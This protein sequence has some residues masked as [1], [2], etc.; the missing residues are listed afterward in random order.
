MI[1]NQIKL[2]KIN[3]KIIENKKA[4]KEFEK[5][6]DLAIERIMKQDYNNYIN[7]QNEINKRIMEL[8]RQN[9]LEWEKQSKSKM[10][11]PDY[12]MSE[13]EKALN[14]ELLEKANA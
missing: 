1:E 12:G 7:S 14:K 5:Q 13:T 10:K 11:N 4:R 2:K 9:I 3:D 6:V 8:N